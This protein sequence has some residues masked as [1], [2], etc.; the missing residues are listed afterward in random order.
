MKKYI[1]QGI[2]SII[3]AIGVLQFLLVPGMMW[4]LAL[5]FTFILTLIGMVR[6]KK[7]KKRH[8]KICFYILSSLLV[9]ELGFH[10]LS[11]TNVSDPIDEVELNVMSYNLFFKNQSPAQS[12]SIIKNSNPDVLF[13][14]E[15]TPNWA[16]ILD[17]NIG[18]TYPFRLT[19]PMNGTHG[20]GIYSK[21]KIQNQHFLNNAYNKPY[22]QI[23]QLKVGKKEIQIINTHLASP[24][25]AVEN[26]ENFAKLYFK[27]YK[28]R[29]EELSSINNWV[30]ATTDKFSAHL[31][32]GD[33]N[34]MKYEPLFK[35]LK[36]NWANSHSILRDGLGFSFP[37]SSRIIPF[38][39]LDYIMGKGKI[40]FIESKVLKGGSSDH[41]AIMSRMKV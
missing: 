26:K 12:I 30:E 25:I 23:A 15:L 16:K 20:I 5:P 38:L 33:L 13:V 32:I 34:T 29:A 10:L 6:I 28:N 21:F 4:N 7:I 18:K 35:K 40:K 8:L 37:H 14:Q 27:N 17:Q 19:K 22:A 3:I 41:L 2:L 31:L 24:A 36:Y 9:F 39:T 11:K 1:G